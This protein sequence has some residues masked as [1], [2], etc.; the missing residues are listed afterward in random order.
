MPYVNQRLYALPAHLVSL[1]LPMALLAYSAMLMD[2]INAQVIIFAVLAKMDMKKIQQAE[3][4]I[5][6][7]SLALHVIHQV[8]AKLV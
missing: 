4:V 3:N 7:L 2:V 6:V 8:D 1:L 5:F